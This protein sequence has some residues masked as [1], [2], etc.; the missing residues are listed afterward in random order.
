MRDLV[1]VFYEVTEK[2]DT[3]RILNPDYILFLIVIKLRDVLRG[4]IVHGTTE[5]DMLYWMSRAALEYV[6][7]GVL[8]YSFQALDENG[9]NAYMK[10]TQQLL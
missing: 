7:V 2:V 3:S 10:A 5:V 1:P 4:K 9:D 6:G 8:G